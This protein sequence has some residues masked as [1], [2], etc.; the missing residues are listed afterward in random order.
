MRNVLIFLFTLLSSS[1]A[2]AAGSLRIEALTDREY[3]REDTRE[4]LSL[5]VRILPATAP[6]DA[7]APLPAARNLA[8]VIDRS[9]SMI[10][11]PAVATEA[12]LKS[13][14]AQLQP[15]DFLSVVAFGSNVTV[16]RE[17]A[18]AAPALD[19]PLSAEPAGGSALYHAPNQAAAQLRR[20]ASPQTVNHLILL[21]DGPPTKA[22][23]ETADFEKLAQ[24]LARENI[25][26]STIGLGE[27]F[28]EDLLAQLA[29]LG[30]GRFHYAAQPDRLAPALLATLPTSAALLA[31]DVQLT[32]SFDTPCENVEAHDALPSTVTDEH[33][34]AYQLPQLVA[35]HE[36]TFFQT[37]RFFPSRFT[38]EVA[39]VR[40][41]WT[42]P[43]DGKTH[44]LKHTVPIEVTNDTRS[45]TESARPPVLRHAARALVSDALQD[46]IEQL[47]KNDPRR[48]LRLL[49]NA[50]SDLNS[51]N[52]ELEDPEIKSLAQQLDTYLA[53]FRQRPLSAADRKFLRSGLDGVFPTP[54]PS[55]KPYVTVFP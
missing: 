9:G 39:T 30:Y 50:R 3:Y 8:V 1:F 18:P 28:P 10:G 14:V 25:T 46:A 31:R 51:L 54:A 26:I 45:S 4:H 11:A 5:H 13:L 23:R 55:A 12:A 15:T 6:T 38:R 52:S 7:P 49:R 24:A 32:V 48:A 17:A 29:R 53:N 47:D 40:L 43:A 19:F 22:P 36:P 34:V 27:E 20:H 33:I 42:D 2:T 16:L 21:T 44:T 35:G 41:T 37:M